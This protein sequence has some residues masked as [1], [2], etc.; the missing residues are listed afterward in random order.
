MTDNRRQILD[1]LAQG[2]INVEESEHLLTL[3]DRPSST[4][5]GKNQLE[6]ERNTAPKYVRVVVESEGESSKKGLTSDRR[7]L[8]SGL[9]SSS[10]P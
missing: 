2:K 5:S 8:S 9:A 6:D 3:V 10:R 4:R 1:M 7:W